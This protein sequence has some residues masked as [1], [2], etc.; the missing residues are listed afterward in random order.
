MTM[1]ARLFFAGAAGALL[2]AVPAQAQDATTDATF[3]GPRIEG[4]FGWDGNNISIKDQRTFGGRGTFNSGSTAS[5]LSIGA[6]AGFDLALDR[7]VVG[8]YAGIDT[9]EVDEPFPSLGVVFK[10]GRNITAGARAGFLATS[11][12]L[13]YVKGGYSNGRIRPDF[14]STATAAQQAVFADFQRNQDGYH[15]GGGV[16]F[17]VT[18]S[19][20]GRIDY[21]HHKY[22]EFQI[23]TNNEFSYDRN[24]LLGGIGFRF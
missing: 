13:V 15:F 6:E 11:N 20:Y 8:A 21:A 9:G 17:A 5:D 12:V 7:I 16:E 14:T 1:N 22:D 24:T 18:R 2:A 3:T 10:T 23:D 19:I 4:R